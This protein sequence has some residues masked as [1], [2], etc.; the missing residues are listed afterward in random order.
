[1]ELSGERRGCVNGLVPGALVFVV[2]ERY[3][4]MWTGVESLVVGT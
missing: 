3:I 2:R 1:M 4:S